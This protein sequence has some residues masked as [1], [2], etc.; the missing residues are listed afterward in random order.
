MANQSLDALSAL[1]SGVD[2]W[3]VPDLDHSKWA[4]RIDWYLNFQIV[5]ARPHVLPRLSS[6]LNEILASAEFTAPE[7]S[8]SPSA[9]LLVASQ[10]LLP[11]RATVVVPWSEGENS[12]REWVRRCHALWRDLSKPYAPNGLSARFFLPGQLSSDAFLKAWPKED[13]SASVQVVAETE[14]DLLRS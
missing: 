1:A 12:Q 6:K 2:L 3:V 7:V 5:R 9:P 11:N 8:V 10:D 14:L 13:S 4:R